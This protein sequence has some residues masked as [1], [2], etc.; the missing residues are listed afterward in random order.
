M[1]PTTNKD[2][3]GLPIPMGIDVD[4]YEKNKC[5]GTKKFQKSGTLFGFPL[6]GPGK[7][8]VDWKREEWNFRPWP[9]HGE[10]YFEAW[11]MWPENDDEYP[12]TVVSLGVPNAKHRYPVL[13]V[14]L[15]FVVSL[16]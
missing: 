12:L 2:Q 1:M 14:F 7:P 10:N 6:V 5:I 15:L 4:W 9:V 3:R 8:Y 11:S 16:N 13:L